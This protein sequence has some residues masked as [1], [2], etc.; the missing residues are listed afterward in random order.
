MRTQTGRKAV[1]TSITSR[2]YAILLVAL[3][4]VP[5]G[6]SGASAELLPGQEVGSLPVEKS[7]GGIVDLGNVD[8]SYAIAFFVPGTKEIASELLEFQ[9][10]LS[11]K[12]YSDYRAFAITR[13]KDE[14]EKQ[15]AAKYLEEH[16][17]DLKLLFDDSRITAARDFGVTAFPTFYIV[18]DKGIVK[19]MA[20][21]VMKPINRLTFQDFLKY[22]EQGREI[23]FVDMMPTGRKT[24]KAKSL[25]DSEA[26]DFTLPD[27]NGTMHSLSS[28]RGKKNVV[29]IFW[30][31][32]C[33][34]CMR[35]LPQVQNFYLSR[36]MDDN[37]EVLAITRGDKEQVKN[38][39]RDK[40][41]TFPVLLDDDG[42][43]MDKYGIRGVPSTYFIDEDGFVVE[44]LVGEARRFNLMYSSIFRDPSRLG[45]K[46]AEDKKKG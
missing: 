34:H 11:S 40:M 13:G 15:R 42:S 29:V 9:R 18:D 12:E 31:P 10:I 45:K 6:S 3:L 46:A 17:I 24:E 43:T 4:A 16:G 37:F 39:V 21:T 2:I 30:S 1:S 33:G 22:I 38:T 8:S 27:I 25:L 26:P 41:F 35:E 32:N 44:I 7:G 19:A 20:N 36:R 23:P 5:A 28:Y 14:S